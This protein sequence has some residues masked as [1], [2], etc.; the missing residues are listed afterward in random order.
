LALGV[1]LCVAGCNAAHYKTS[2]DRE[3][4]GIISQKSSQV[5]GMEA[6]FSLDEPCSAAP[7]AAGA[8][9]E[10]IVLSLA[11]AIAVAAAQSRAFRNEREEVYL[12]ALDLTYQR[13]LWGPRF[14]GGLAGGWERS[15]GESSL[16]SELAFGVN[17]ALAAGGEV[18]LELG[19]AFLMYLSG[20]PRKGAES[21][22]EL[23]IVQP[24]W[25]GSGKSVAQEGLTQAERDMVYALRSF[26][27]FRREFFVSVASDYYRVLQQQDTVENEAL[28]LQN[29]TTAR[30]RAEMLAQ[31]G[32]VPEYEVDQT[33]QD[34]L[35]ARAR[36]VS[37]LEQYD[38]LVDEFKITLGY[39]TDVSLEL[40]R[41]EMDR[42]RDAGLQE[43][44]HTREHA[45]E[46]ALMCRLD[47]ASARDSVE[48]AE[49]KVAVAIDNLG[50][51]LDFVAS[52]GI[53]TEGTKKPLKFTTHDGV[54][55]AG[56]ELDLPL[57]RLE[58]RNAYREALITLDREE[59][60]QSLLHDQVVQQVYNAWRTLRTALESYKIQQ[61][62]VDLAKK[63]VEITS[64]LIDAGRAEARDLLDAQ[65]SLLDARNALTSELV[66]YRIAMLELYRDMGTLTFKDGE[67][68][69][70]NPDVESTAAP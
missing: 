16:T 56:L 69:E 36:W 53:G 46:G 50:A 25:R 52:A 63:R 68:T 14:S 27:R 33:R 5:P 8:S 3:V 13:Y 41:E 22:L 26:V 31:A 47:L 7:E 57:D 54:Y 44:S 45:V 64:V 12:A 19:S 48:D 10:P 2:A 35:S 42:L 21:L 1:A 62:S 29:L 65:A 43:V 18:S 51:D 9:R 23:S 38:S 39:P 28:N 66:G 20:D 24:L 15:G 6:S 59:R 61:M 17:K 30:E 37:A 32:R 60:S 40:D 55:S 67:F 70:A 49:R 58:E 34:E 4:Y 11:D